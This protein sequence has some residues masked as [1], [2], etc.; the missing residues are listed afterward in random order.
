[1]YNSLGF[2]YFWDYTN[3][4]DYTSLPLQSK[5]ALVLHR[6]LR[7]LEYVSIYLL[8]KSP[9][10][11]RTAP[12]CQRGSLYANLYLKGCFCKLWAI[13]WYGQRLQ[14]H[15]NFGIKCCIDIYTTV[16]NSPCIWACVWWLYAVEWFRDDRGLGVGVGWCGLT[17]IAV[18]RNCSSSLSRSENDK[19][20]GLVCSSNFWRCPVNMK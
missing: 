14:M 13:P 19:P 5:V 1:M 7:I 20:P 12:K 11:H 4:Q 8:A 9:I 6:V 16:V 2:I 17:L 18:R 10:F 3:F 15:P